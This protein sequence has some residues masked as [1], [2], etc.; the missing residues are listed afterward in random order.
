MSR[1][2]TS[3]APRYRLDMR[4]NSLPDFRPSV[5]G[6]RFI[7]RWPT[8]PAF[9]FRAGY[10]R[11]G[12]GEVADGLCGGMSF[13]VADRYLAGEAIPDD[14]QPPP[15]GSPLFREIA[16]RQLDSL[17]RL[18]IVPARFLLTAARVAAGRWTAARQVAE[19]RQIV[20]NID[21]GRP[22]MVGLVRSAGFNPFHLTANHQ[23]LAYAYEA[24]TDAASLRM[25]DPNHPGA[26]DVAITIR[27]SDGESGRRGFAC[28]QSTGEPLLAII[29]LPY[30]PAVSR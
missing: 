30:E 22:A 5:H 10:V 12:V 21:A 27:R 23:V 25:Y 1:P 20:T 9:E 16:R 8:G 2:V 6:F 29:R 3:L 18:A 14:T 11:L 7:N 26:D 17:D 19:W 15:S 28:N 4:A 13:A 24:T